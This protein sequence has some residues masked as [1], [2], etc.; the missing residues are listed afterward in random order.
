MFIAVIIPTTR[1]AWNW[2]DIG[3]GLA[4]NAVILAAVMAVMASVGRYGRRRGASDRG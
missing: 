2:A 1:G 3:I 4:T